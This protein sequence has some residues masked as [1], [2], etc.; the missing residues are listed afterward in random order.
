[1][2][3]LLLPLPLLSD[4]IDATATRVGHGVFEYSD[5]ELGDLLKDSKKYFKK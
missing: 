2:N 1:M 3:L 5:G 4:L